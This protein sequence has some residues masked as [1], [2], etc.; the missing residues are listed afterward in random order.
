MQRRYLFFLKRGMCLKTVVAVDASVVF[1]VLDAVIFVVAEPMLIFALG[2]DAL[3]VG[4]LRSAIADHSYSLFFV[5]ACQVS[6][7]C[8]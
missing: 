7:K 6:I 8:L 3:Q 1:D 2:K 4:V 5:L